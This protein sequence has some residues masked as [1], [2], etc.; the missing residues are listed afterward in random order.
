MKS[1][2]GR[3]KA[4]VQERLCYFQKCPR[5]PAAASVQESFLQDPA[6][7]LCRAKLRVDKVI[8]GVLLKDALSPALYTL[9]RSSFM[10]SAFFFMYMFLVLVSRFPIEK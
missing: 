6:D 8:A 5:F 10:M 9:R 7:P 2:P 4:Q 3:R 1:R